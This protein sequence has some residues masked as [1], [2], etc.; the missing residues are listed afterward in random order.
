MTAI[1]IIAE[2][3]PFHSGHAYHLQRAR[4][5][6]GAD[7]IVV[8]ISSD[9]TQR[10]TP[11]VLNMHERARMALLGG[12]DIVLELPVHY[13]CASAGY[14]ARSAVSILDRLKVDALA[15]GYEM[16]DGETGAAL[17]KAAEYLSTQ[18]EKFR[19][20]LKEKLSEGASYASARAFSLQEA[21]G[22]PLSALSGPNNI[23]A[24]EY[25]TALSERNSGMGVV[26]IPRKGS[27]YHSLSLSAPYSS[28]S[29]IR[30]CLQ[31][32]HGRSLE[33]LQGLLPD[34]SLEILSENL[35]GRPPITQDDMSD[36]LTP[37]LTEKDPGDG[38]FD[39]PEGL[40]S[41]LRSKYIPGMTFRELSG[42]LKSRNI[43]QTAVDRALIHILLQIRSDAMRDYT[44]RDYVEYA[45]LLG[46]KK[47][48][49]PF[50]HEAKKRGGLTLLSK[51][52][53]YALLLSPAGKRMFEEDLRGC[54]IY[55]ALERRRYG[56]PYTDELIRSPI[57][58]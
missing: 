57:V 36:M 14:F 16:S 29:A 54:R 53:R 10:G 49:A 50:L 39:V 45:R 24:L 25:L 28:A 33:K 18:P 56:L 52:S 42:A 32:E 22:I 9:F 5:E 37:L 34:T 3:D 4:E 13:S 12:A 58:L 43:S 48:S 46:L 15:F 30:A 11:S 41:R 17:K 47:N 44:E 26:M 35:S 20:L 38:V 1:G 8:V 51:P 21:A 6:S 55:S 31:S 2:Y 40:K 27:G 23:L 7:I 19:R